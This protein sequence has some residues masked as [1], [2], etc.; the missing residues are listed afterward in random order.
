MGSFKKFFFFFY[1]SSKTSQAAADPLNN[2]ALL[3]TEDPAR[4]SLPGSR[5]SH[6]TT[7]A[8][9]NRVTGWK[10]D[11]SPSCTVVGGGQRRSLAAVQ[12]SGA[13]LPEKCLAGGERL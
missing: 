13:C 4:P 3:S 6:T 12:P 11:T 10:A 9:G 1:T 7:A 5:T 8:K 2:A